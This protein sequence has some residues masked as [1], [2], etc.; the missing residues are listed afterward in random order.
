[1]ALA[2]KQEM[3]V[4]LC[5]LLMTFRCPEGKKG[6]RSK[7]GIWWLGDAAYWLLLGLGLISSK[8]RPKGGRREGWSKGRKEGK[9]ESKGRREKRAGMNLVV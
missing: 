2:N 3:G 1:M 4:E 5:F 9:G 6:E 8:K 7:N